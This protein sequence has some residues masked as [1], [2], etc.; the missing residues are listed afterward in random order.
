MTAITVAYKNGVKMDTDYYYGFH[1][2]FIEDS[3]TKWGLRRTEVRKIVGT[4]SGEAAPYQVITTL[5][6]DNMPAFSDAMA[7]KDGRAVLADIHKF[8]ADMPDIMIGEV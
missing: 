6:F 7:S 4:P 5:Y 3:L 2:P 1:V 8:Y